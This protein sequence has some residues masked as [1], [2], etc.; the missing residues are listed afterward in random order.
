MGDFGFLT[1]DIE[2][3]KRMAG[4]SARVKHRGG[5]LNG[6]CVV[7]R[8]FPNVD[9][10]PCR[11][12]ASADLADGDCAILHSGLKRRQD[13]GP[14]AKPRVLRRSHHSLSR[15]QSHTRLKRK[16]DARGLA[17]SIVPMSRCAWRGNSWAD[18]LQ[19]PTPT[20]TLPAS[21]CRQSSSERESRWRRGF[22]ISAKIRFDALFSAQPT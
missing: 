10:I 6:L 18:L 8:D 11:R 4:S 19:D 3:R 15:P 17:R 21:D 13:H 5:T 7:S 9:W 20:H 14:A 22:F 16:L 2:V 1:Y 12:C